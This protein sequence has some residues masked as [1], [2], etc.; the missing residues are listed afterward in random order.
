MENYWQQIGIC[1]VLHILRECCKLKHSRRTHDFFFVY[2]ESVY[3]VAITVK[4]IR[5]MGEGFPT[6][7]YVFLSK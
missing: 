4:S 1:C 5:R 6:I 2:V 7:S 3:G